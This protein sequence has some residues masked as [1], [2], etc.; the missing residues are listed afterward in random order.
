MKYVVAVI[1]LL[2][3]IGIPMGIFLLS[4]AEHDTDIVH[5]DPLLIPASETPNDYRVAPRDL[6]NERVDTDAPIYFEKPLVLAQA[7]DQFLLSQRDTYRIAGLPASLMMSYVQH[8]ETLKMPDYIT[9]KF[10]DL[11][12]GKATVA[13]YSRSRYGYGDQGMNKA[14]VDR[15][16]G[17]LTSFEAPKTALSN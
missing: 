10:I 17:A 14:R 4:S 5:Q 6:T 3:V 11:G 16:L 15:W 13:I 8:T 9:V 7:F 2:I 1:A 12:E